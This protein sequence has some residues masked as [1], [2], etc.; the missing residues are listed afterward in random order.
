[1]LRPDFLRGLS[2]LAEFDLTYDL[3]LRP[4]NLPAAVEVV[5]QF[6]QQ[7]FVVDHIAKPLIK[8]GVLAPWEAGLRALAR[9][10]NVYCK[11][12]GMVNEAAWRA[13][14]PADF[15]PY[16]DVVFDCFGA[17]RLMFGSDWPVCTLAADYGETASL[18]RDTVRPMGPEV[19]AAVMGGNA[20]E[21]YGL[22]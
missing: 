17:G 21:F 10:D 7:R 1:M 20:I 6:P 3:L 13:W 16:L 11:L 19:E 4:Q 15:R 14:K 5:R 18:V 2:V 22:A 12:S 9:F 8:E